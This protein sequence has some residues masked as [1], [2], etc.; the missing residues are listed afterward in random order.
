MVSSAILGAIMEHENMKRKAKS[1]KG[2]AMKKC[3][4]SSDAEIAILALFIVFFVISI[5]LVYFLFKPK[6]HL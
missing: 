5:I 1:E 3:H 4:F 6:K 2:H